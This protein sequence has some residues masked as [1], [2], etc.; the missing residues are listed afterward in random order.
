MGNKD[1]KMSLY[2]VNP[3]GRQGT[4][5]TFFRFSLPR[6]APEGSSEME[7]RRIVEP[8][9][10]TI[11]ERKGS[12]GTVLIAVILLLA[13]LIG[14]WFLLAQNSSESRRDAAV[15]DAAQSV[16]SAADK[17]GDAVTPKGE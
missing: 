11:I 8:G 10:T 14:G 15:T 7:E 16:G 6:G 5:A 12:G 2:E 3:P 13:L 9:H 4:L 17:L 1:I